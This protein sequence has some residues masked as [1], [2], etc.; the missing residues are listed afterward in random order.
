MV[1]RRDVWFDSTLVVVPSTSL[2]LLYGGDT[3]LARVLFRFWA[4]GFCLTKVGGVKG[5]GKSC[6]D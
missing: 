6:W 2:S 3:I 4:I 5:G 1:Q